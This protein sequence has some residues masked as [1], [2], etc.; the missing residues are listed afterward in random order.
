MIINIFL[1]FIFSYFITYFFIPIF[2]NKLWGSFPNKRTS[3][4]GFIPVGGSLGFIIV[5]LINFILN[6][7]Y[8]I[9]LFLILSFI[10]LADDLKSLG[11]RVRLFIQ[12]LVGMIFTILVY[13]DTIFN[14]HI[15]QNSLF[16]GNILAIAFMTFLFVSIVNL[17]NFADG[18]DGLLTG[19][20]VII[21]LFASY[22]S[23][24]NYIY[25][26]GGL[27]GFLI[28]NWYPAKVFMG[29][30]GSYFLGSVYCSCLV[31]SNSWT[32]F[33]AL[34]LIGSPLYFD[35]IF[36]V[37]RRFFHKQNV[38]QAHKLNLYQRLNQNGLNHW[39]ISFIY[40]SSKFLIGLSFVFG[41]IYSMLVTSLIIL[42]I[43]IY[44]DISV[45]L[46]FKEAMD[47]N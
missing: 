39:Q 25:L 45:A 28:L 8:Y 7:K 16:I 47:K 15:F 4:R 14:F 2:K 22:L 12:I 40:I 41:N 20:M 6:K 31:L 13:K 44:L 33:T 9:F 11:N 21:F 24:T 36:C 10:G 46:P 3:H 35:V 29:D 5:S 32:N 19:S 27:L 42:G 17:T 1:S 30:S 26:V 38:F 37:I 34:L 43:G 18:L 23:D